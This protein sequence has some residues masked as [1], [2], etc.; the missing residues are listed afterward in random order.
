[1]TKDTIQDATGG[2]LTYSEGGL[3]KDYFDGG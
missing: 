1:M 3:I 2:A